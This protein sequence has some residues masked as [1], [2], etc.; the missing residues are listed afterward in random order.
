M[1]IV[2]EQLNVKTIGKSGKSRA[3]YGK[4]KSTV[5]LSP[6]I[7]RMSFYRQ[8]DASSNELLNRYELNAKIM[9]LLQK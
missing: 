8:F 6:V 4:R 5:A 1:R 9:K 3:N 7:V 2:D